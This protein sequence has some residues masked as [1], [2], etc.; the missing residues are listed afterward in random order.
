MRETLG[1]RDQFKKASTGGMLVKAVLGPS[2]VLALCFPYSLS[3]IVSSTILSYSHSV[4]PMY[5]AKQL[6]IELLDSR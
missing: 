2:S 6:W 3:L 5:W 4:V 1:G